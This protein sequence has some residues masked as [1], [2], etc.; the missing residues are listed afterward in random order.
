M[1]LPIRRKRMEGM[2]Q[3]MFDRLAYAHPCLPYWAA[4]ALV[5]FRSEKL[6]DPGAVA[7]GKLL[8]MSGIRSRPTCPAVS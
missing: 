2:A 3:P 5:P 8:R 7:L 1:A 4:S 6:S